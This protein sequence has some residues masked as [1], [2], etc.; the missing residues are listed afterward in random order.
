[1]KKIFLSTIFFLA[2]SLALQAQMGWAIGDKFTFGHSWTN[3]NK[4][5]NN[6]V[7]FHPFVQ[8]GRNAVYNF[9]NNF[10]IGLGTFFSTE[11]VSF[12][13]ESNKRTIESCMNYIRVPVFANF[14]FGDTDKRVRPKLSLGPSIGFLIG[15]KSLLKNKDGYLAGVKTLKAMS[16]N[17][18]AGANISVGLNV[19]LM[20]GVWINHD[21]SYYH[22]LVRNEYDVSGFSFGLTNTSSFTHR[23]I[24]LNMG[25]LISGDAMRKWK[26]NMHRMR[27]KNY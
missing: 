7:K 11:G 13:D 20:D 27:H 16:T 10:G 14:I 22:G 24:G 12:Y 4:P 9:N 5:D 26:N 6:K 25:M 8:L 18:D 23:N 21:I 3:G 1:M 15:G 17:I 19:K 2:A